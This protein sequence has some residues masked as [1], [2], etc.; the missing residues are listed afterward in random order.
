MDA[1]LH[2]LTNTVL[3]SFVGLIMFGIAFVAMEKFLPFP[4]RK[5][6]EEDQ[7]TALAIIMAAVMIGIAMIISA[8]LHG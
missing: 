3:F 1:M 8:A 5:E 6:I 4:I 7:N 2:A